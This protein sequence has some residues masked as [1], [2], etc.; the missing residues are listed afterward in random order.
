MWLCGWKTSRTMLTKLTRL[1]KPLTMYFLRRAHGLYKYKPEK[2][3]SPSFWESEGK[4]ADD[5][6]GFDAIMPGIEHPLG[7][8]RISLSDLCYSV[9]LV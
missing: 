6:S 2:T 1:Q 7:L 3:L 4:N 8:H 9:H 5:R